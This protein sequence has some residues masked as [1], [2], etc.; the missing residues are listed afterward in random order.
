MQGFLLSYMKGAAP[1]M[2]KLM[3]ARTLLTPS[4]YSNPINAFHI[5][6]VSAVFSSLRLTVDDALT[7]GVLF[8]GRPRR[9]PKKVREE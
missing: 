1:L 4:F 7:E 3:A 5:N 9:V 6:S 8:V 2:S